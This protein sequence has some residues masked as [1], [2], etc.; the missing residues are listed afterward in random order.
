MLQRF[1]DECHKNGGL[2][3]GEPFEIERT[4]LIGQKGS[5]KMAASIAG[6]YLKLNKE[7][8]LAE[9]IGYFRGA[10]VI[11]AS[12]PKRVT[13]RSHLRDGLCTQIG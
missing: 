13:P 7:L 5:F 11:F 1:A 6:S 10:L 2:Y 9:S 3:S 12:Y 4:A 8:S